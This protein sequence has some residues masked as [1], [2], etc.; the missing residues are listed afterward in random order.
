MVSQ[1]SY[2]FIIA[3]ADEASCCA[4]ESVLEIVFLPIAVTCFWRVVRYE[5]VLGKDGVSPLLSSKDCT[6]DMD[7]HDLEALFCPP[8]WMVCPSA[9]TRPLQ[10]WSRRLVSA[11]ALLSWDTAFPVAIH[12]TWSA[13]RKRSPL[14]MAW[15][16]W[17]AHA[18]EVR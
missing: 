9:F 5:G 7:W 1:I 11:L 18:S 6:I 15:T 17:P 4:Q 13:G 16:R 3:D 10:T 14:T 8:C 2:L 12:I